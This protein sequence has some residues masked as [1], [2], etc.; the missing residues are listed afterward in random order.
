MSARGAASTIVLLALLVTLTTA[1]EPPAIV[2]YCVADQ[3]QEDHMHKMMSDSLDHAFEEHISHLFEIWIK[4][5]A[6]QPARAVNGASL[7]VNAYVRAQRNLANWHP[8]RC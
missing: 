3:Q 7:G 2:K 5:P 1:T 6:E 4:D 8:P